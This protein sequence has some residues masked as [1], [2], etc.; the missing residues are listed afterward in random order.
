MDP[1]AS[2]DHARLKVTPEEL[3]AAIAELTSVQDKLVAHLVRTGHINLARSAGNMAEK[4]RD[5]SPIYRLTLTLQLLLR[6]IEHERVDVSQ[7]MVAI[8]RGV[9]GTVSKCLEYRVTIPISSH[10][11]K[12]FLELQPGDTLPDVIKAAFQQT[13]SRGSL[14]LVERAREVF[15]PSVS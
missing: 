2:I 14:G 5:M 13:Q 8:S 10:V 4:F 7:E 3:N 11:R 9:F 12:E 15:G 6:G 1:V